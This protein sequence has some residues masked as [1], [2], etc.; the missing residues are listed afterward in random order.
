MP[1]PI[2]NSRIRLSQGL[3]FWRE[4]GQGSALVFLHGSWQDSS[5]WMPVVEQLS[6]DYHCIV[7]DLLGFGESDNPDV[8]YSIALEVECLAEFLRALKLQQIYLVGHSLGGWVATSFALKYIDQVAGVV[9]LAPEGMQTWDRKDRWFGA[10]LLL[11]PWVNWGLRSLLPL[12][13]F[14]K[15]RSIERLLEQRQHLLHSLTACKLLFYRRRAE[16]RAE[17]V[18]DSL[19]WLKI[20]VLVLQAERDRSTTAALNTTCV[21]LAPEAELKLLPQV[22]EEVLETQPEFVARAIREFIAKVPIR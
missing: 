20:P 5:Q 12:S 11:T 3:I 19:R 6:Q 14:L 10:R 1:L 4:V 7:P 8:H 2:R 13:R 9:L 18:N 22:G 16:I 21:Q 17:L 15:L